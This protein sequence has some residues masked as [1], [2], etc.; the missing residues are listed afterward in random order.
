[1]VRY[2]TDLVGA[3]ADEGDTSRLQLLPRAVE[4][5]DQEDQVGR[6][7]AAAS[8]DDAVVGGSVQAEDHLAGV[9]LRLGV[10]RLKHA[11]TEPPLVEGERL[12]EIVH[13]E[14]QHGG[15]SPGRGGRGRC[16]QGWAGA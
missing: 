10:T 11:E 13:V 1:E 6:V 15:L 4:V 14:A 3:P 16:F 7:V 12:P 2:P 8:E 5:I 9:E